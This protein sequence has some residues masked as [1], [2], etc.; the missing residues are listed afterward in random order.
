MGILTLVIGRGV[1]ED[2]ET[3]YFIGGFWPSHSQSL[4]VGLI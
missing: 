1:G 2:L 3:L 4:N